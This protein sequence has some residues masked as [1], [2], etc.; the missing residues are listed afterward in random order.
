MDL[1][2][3]GAVI[4]LVDID[5]SDCTLDM[6]AF[7]AA[8]SRRTRLVAVTHASNAVGTI[9]D[10]ARIVR[11][12]HDAGA[13]VFVDAVQYAP[14][15]P[16]DVRA[17]DC[18]FLACSAYKFFGPHVGVLYGKIE[19]LKRIKPY[20]VRPAKVEPPWCWETGTSN[21]EGIAGV[22][23]AAGYLQEL[24]SPTV[25]SD[26][27]HKSLQSAMMAIREYEKV[28]CARLLNGLHDIDGVRIYG[29][30][31]TSR[32]DERLPVV[33]FTLPRMSPYE[34]ARLLAKENIFCWSGNYYALRL[35]ERLGLEAEGGAVRIGLAHYNTVEEIDRLIDVLRNVD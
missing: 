30:T 3:S 14:H 18:D 6:S 20:K 35:M 26:D 21:H 8:L 7:E 13:L 10:V 2:E 28:L 12:A 15:G 11:L 4:R 9:P 31:E 34:I 22:A 19:H 16:I 17:L 29:I 1:K 5:P 33:A 27:G 23:A 24:A 32:L 25:S